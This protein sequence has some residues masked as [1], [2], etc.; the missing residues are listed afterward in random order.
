MPVTTSRNPLRLL[1]LVGLAA[2]AFSAAPVL[3]QDSKPIQTQDTNVSGVVAELMECKREEGVLT[4]RVRYRNTTDK[5]VS[6]KVLNANNF[7]AYYVTAGGK[8]YLM[9]RD[10]QKMTLSPQVLQGTGQLSVKLDK[11]GTYQWWAKYP[12]PVAD[13]KKISYYTPLTAPFDNVP[14]SD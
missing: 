14:I 11:G 3:A 12:A 7:D 9:M 10:P 6:V 1:L 5:K 8:K 4:V 13:V 2:G